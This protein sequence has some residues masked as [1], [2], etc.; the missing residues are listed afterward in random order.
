MN[1][2]EVGKIWDGNADAWTCLSRMGCDHYRDL[3]N[4]PSFLKMLPDVVGLKGLDVGCGE[5]HNTRLIAKLGSNVTAFDIS[6]TFVRHAKE[7]ES[8]KPLGIHYHVASA[9]ELPYPVETFDFVTAF[10]SIMD[11]P[12]QESAIREI[13][14]VLKPGGFFQFSIC[15]PCFVTRR[16][17]KVYE[18]NGEI[19]AV[20][21]GDYF[22]PIQDEIEEWIFSAAPSELKAELN[23]FRVPRF[24]LILSDWLNILIDAGFI[25]ER[26]CEPVAD[27]ETA[28]QHP[29]VADTRIVGFFFIIRC[30][31]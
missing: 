24:D 9:V 5:G 15:H 27:E 23:P 22:N 12:E 29:E 18:D 17:R 13:N 16:W 6:R 25:L 2:Y 26:F 28:L 1:H 20:E 21:C 3:V 30:R 10:M 4:T 11:L 19:V 14:R 7:F 31:K 8:D